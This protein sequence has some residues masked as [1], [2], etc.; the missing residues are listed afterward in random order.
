MYI[1]KWGIGNYL[2]GYRDP[3]VQLDMSLL[4]TRTKDFFTEPQTICFKIHFYVLLFERFSKISLPGQGPE[5]RLSTW[6][7]C[8]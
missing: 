2:Y 3:S 4:V 1:M 5:S 7:W 6:S 8:L